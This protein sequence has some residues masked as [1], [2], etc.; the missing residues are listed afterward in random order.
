[1]KQDSPV[2]THRK[3]VSVS[4]TPQEKEFLDSMDISPTALIKQKIIEVMG[5]TLA[6]RTEIKQKKDALEKLAAE[7]QKLYDEFEDYKKQ[8]PAGQN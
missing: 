5:G 8:H 7:Y 2:Y 4:L 6:L 1:M 3:I